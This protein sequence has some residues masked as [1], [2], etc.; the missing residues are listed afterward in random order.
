MGTLHEDQCTFMVICR[1]VILRMRNCSDKFVEKIKTHILCPITFIVFKNRTVYEIILKNIV[2]RGRPHMTIGCTRIACWIPEAANN[3]L[4]ISNTYCLSTATMVWRTRYNVYCI[5]TLHFWFKIHIFCAV[6]SC[7]W[8]WLI[9]GTAVR[10]ISPFL[11]LLQVR[12][13]RVDQQTFRNFMAL[14]SRISS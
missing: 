14:F 6:I 8:S 3:I 7:S 1:S 4:T 2:K 5:R 12:R 10:T 11:S 13:W 9:N